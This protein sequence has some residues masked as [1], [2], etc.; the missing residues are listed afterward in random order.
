MRSQTSPR[1]RVRPITVT[2]AVGCLSLAV[3]PARAQ[4]PAKSGPIPSQLYAKYVGGT[5]SMGKGKR[6]KVAVTFSEAAVEMTGRRNASLSI[7]LVEITRVD[8]QNLRPANVAVAG[9]KT[10]GQVE[11]GF[12]QG[13]YAD[14]GA[15][16]ILFGMFGFLPTAVISSG[17]YSKDKYVVK[18]GWD[19]ASGHHEALLQL[20]A[21]EYSPFLSALRRATGGN[22][23]DLREEEQR[24]QKNAIEHV[25]FACPLHASVAGQALKQG[26]YQI[27]AVDREGAPTSLIFI[28]GKS[29]NP[30]RVRMIVPAEIVQEPASEPIAPVVSER[31]G[32]SM[33]V[34]EVNIA[35][36]RFRVKTESTPPSKPS[37]Q[38]GRAPTQNH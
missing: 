29:L 26:R 30:H 37:D 25:S 5:E 19:E 31:D 16:A 1:P 23:L 36:K 8:S 34:T 35:G 6:M 21:R 14:S 38:Q 7:P 33:R 28:A 18:I 4:E 17:V 20:G 10:A 3:S 15:T 2:L 32:A 12:A 11:G 9:L 13:F 27:V 24:L 22:W